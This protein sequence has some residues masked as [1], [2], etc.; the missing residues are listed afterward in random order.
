VVESHTGGTLP[1]LLRGG[2]LMG[3][4]SSTHIFNIVLW[5][6]DSKMDDPCGPSQVSWPCMYVNRASWGCGRGWV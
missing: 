4:K 1:G 6:P 3:N 5:V 2:E